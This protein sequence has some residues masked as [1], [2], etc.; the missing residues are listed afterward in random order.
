MTNEQLEDLK[1]EIRIS[2]RAL[3]I[4]NVAS[5]LLSGWLPN[6]NEKPAIH[7]DRVMRAIY[8]ARDIVYDAETTSVAKELR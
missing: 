7:N 3:E 2:V 8:L 1:R 6:G 4:S 5:T